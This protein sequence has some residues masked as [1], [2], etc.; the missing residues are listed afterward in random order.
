MNDIASHL[1]AIL[2]RLCRAVGAYVANQARGPQLVWLGTQ[3]FAPTLAPNQPALL[4][5]ET[6]LLLTQ[7]LGRLAHRFRVL[8]ARFHA[9]TL[10]SPRPSGAGLPRERTPKPRL[11]AT[12]G[13]IGARI[14]DAAPCAG[15]IEFMLH[16]T[17]QMQDFV[18]AAPQA[19]RL[20]RPLCRML[21]IIMPDWLRRPAR[22]RKAP[23][24]RP[25]APDTTGTPDR[26]IP[27]NILAAARAW[28]SKP[29]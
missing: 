4:P 10:P 1:T 6:W 14:A 9:G 28:R 20:L 21:G 23:A 18:R 26:P 13:W 12:A 2:G 22:V 15:T 5:S 24:P 27:R 29:T 16:N 7:R 11:P 25:A 8:F 19:G 17:P 3:A